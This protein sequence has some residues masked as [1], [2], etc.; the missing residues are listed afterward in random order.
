M[1]PKPS[2]VFLQH[3]DPNQ[4]LR[5]RLKRYEIQEVDLR[6]Q[7]KVV[8]EKIESDYRDLHYPILHDKYFGRY[9]KQSYSHDGKKKWWVYKQVISM[10]NT[11]VYPVQ[12]GPTALCGIWGFQTDLAGD[13]RIIRK[14]TT[15]LHSLGTQID[16]AEFNEA[17]NKMIDNI[18]GVGTWERIPKR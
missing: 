9:F 14:E 8:Q 12:D 7:L 5:D 6:S 16:K 17:Y 13:I 15:Y 2:K 4:S 11:D 10:K 3:K 1:R 18:N